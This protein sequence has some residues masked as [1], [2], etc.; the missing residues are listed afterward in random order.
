MKEFCLEKRRLL[1]ASASPRRRELLGE[2]GYEFEI[3]LPQVAEVSPAHLTTGEMALFNARL[4][5]N[6]VARRFPDAVVLGADT[7]VSLD[8]VPIGKPND[9]ADAHRMLSQLSGRLHQVYSGVAVICHA[10]G[11]VR[12]GVEV[13]HVR[14]HRLTAAEI[15]AY[16]RRI[17]PLDKAGA[18]AAQDVG[19]GSVVSGIEGSRTNVIGLPMELLGRLLRGE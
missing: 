5:A 2:Y 18:Y 17:E 15:E 1:L 11:A 13:S 14:F 16:L 6:E 3:E 10:T 9:L 7:L 19:E 8:G 12:T 4:K